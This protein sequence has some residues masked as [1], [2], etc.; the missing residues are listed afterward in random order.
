MSSI[1]NTSRLDK[2][3]RPV[4]RRVEPPRPGIGPQRLVQQQIL[5]NRQQQLL[6]QQQQPEST[7]TDFPLMSTAKRGKHHIMDFKSPKTVDPKSFARPVKLHREKTDFLPYRQYIAKIAAQNAA[8]EEQKK[9]AQA[10]AEAIMAGKLIPTSPP[11]SQS[12]EKGKGKE[13]VE[14]VGGEEN[15]SNTASTKS[16]HGPKS[17]ADTSLIAPLG[18]ATRNKQLLFKKRTKQIYLAKEDTRELKEQEHRPWILEDYDSQHSFTG[19]YEGGQRSDYMFFVLTDNGFRVVLVDRWYK[20]QPKRHFK[21]LSLEAEEQ[22]KKQQKRENGRW[23]MLNRSKEQEEEERA[24]S[25]L[26]KFKIVDH[27][28]SGK[29]DSDMDDLDFDDVFQ[30]DEEGTGE[31]EVED[32]EIK[33]SKDRVKKE[34]KDYSINSGQD[35]DDDDILMKDNNGLSSEGK[36]LHK[37]VRD[38]EKNRAYESDDEEADPYASSAE[39]METDNDEEDESKKTEDE[40]KEKNAHMPLKKKISAT[41]NNAH[42]SNLTPKKMHAN[43][44]KKEAMSKPLGRP[45][46]PSIYMKKKEHGENVSLSS[47]SV[48]KPSSPLSTAAETTAAVKREPSPTSPLAHQHRP[49][50]LIGISNKDSNTK[51]RRIEGRGNHLL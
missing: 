33:D 31:H 12:K 41:A 5:Q 42:K 49:S 19:T 40:K 3:K 28:N 43:K 47:R 50:S 13:T 27:N 35:I 29:E 46:S 36:Q 45:G 21:H 7:Y 4:Q 18:G 25:H 17:G 23:M 38:L 34:I 2:S 48:G 51:K 22:M 9:A 39:E 1:Y 16:Q 20:F 11:S 6:Q 44:L 10:K 8:N 32:E 14:E 15:K 30:D 37:L 26:G 24:A